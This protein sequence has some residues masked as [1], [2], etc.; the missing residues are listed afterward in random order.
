MNAFEQ[1][2]R[3]HEK[4]LERRNR[5]VQT[6]VLEV[7]E[8]AEPVE[9]SKEKSKTDAVISVVVSLPSGDLVFSLQ[10]RNVM[11]NIHP[12]RLN[13]NEFKNAM[14]RGLEPL[15]GRVE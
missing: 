8:P 4:N 9:M 13:V 12:S 1:A 14:I 3:R 2:K 11:G 15:L 5:M 6:Q 7:V 10:K